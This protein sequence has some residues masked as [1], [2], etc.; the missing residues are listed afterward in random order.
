MAAVGTRSSSVRGKQWGNKGG[1]AGRKARRAGIC[2]PLLVQLSP[3]VSGEQGRLGVVVQFTLP[4]QEGRRSKAVA[5]TVRGAPMSEWKTDGGKQ[6]GDGRNSRIK[7]IF[8]FYLLWAGEGRWGGGGG[9]AADSLRWRAGW[10][11]RLITVVLLWRQTLTAAVL[12]KRIRVLLLR[13]LAMVYCKESTKTWWWG[14]RGVSMH[15]LQ[16]TERG[17]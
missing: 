4:P 9:R 13:E 10:A 14:G 5:T 16:I 12:L 17:I 8:F 7:G 1:C 2:H 6:S 3:T 11:L 15:Y